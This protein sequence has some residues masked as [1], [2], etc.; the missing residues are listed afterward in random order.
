MGKRLGI[1]IPYRNR[2]DQ[3]STFK[4]AIC[5]YLDDTDIDYKIIIV[6]QDDEKLFNR[7]KLLNIGFAKAKKLRCNYVIFHDIDMLPDEVDYSYSPIPLHL[8]TNEV[9]E[10]GE[11]TPVFE[12]YFGGVTLFPVEMFES[13]NGYSNDYWGWGFEDD[14]LLHRCKLAHI[15]LN[16]TKKENIGAKTSALRFNGVNSFV[17]FKNNFNFSRDLTL[18]ISFRPDE[19][20]LNPDQRDDA[21]AAFGIPGYDLIIGYNSFKRYVVE[22]FDSKPEFHNLYSDIE[23][24]VNVNVILTY[25]ARERKFVLY[26]NGEKVDSKVIGNRVYNY[27]RSE[28]VYLGVGNPNTNDY[29]KFFKGDIGTFASYN[30]C[31]DEDQ[32]KSLGSNSHFGLGTNFENYTDSHALTN[33]FDAKF[34]FDYKLKNLINSDN[35]G[36]IVNC[37]IEK[38]EFVEYTDIQIPFRRVSRFKLLEHEENGFTGTSWKDINT[39][40]NQLKFVN[41]F[42]KGGREYIEDGLSN[43]KYKTFSEVK[44]GKIT[45]LTVGI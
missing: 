43:L 1:I 10:Q 34:I 29:P 24:C 37:S 41:E 18:L 16:T 15:P 40:Y 38:L 19:L 17:K 4:S 3:L 35:D 25:Q 14:D 11:L 22:L 39:R 26:I 30:K 7:G 31:L 20:T 12:E 13:I 23:N 9:S 28:Y 33:Y 2:Y 8:A 44:E 21:G 6:E 36:E 5:E 45:T 42:K 32:I 27:K